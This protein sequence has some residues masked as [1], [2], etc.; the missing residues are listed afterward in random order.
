[1]DKKTFQAY[2][3]YKYFETYEEAREGK[4][5]IKLIIYAI[6]LIF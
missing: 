5:A 6:K 3:I 2:E 1:M 4:L